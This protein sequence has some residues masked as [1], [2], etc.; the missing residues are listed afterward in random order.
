MI[1]E[2]KVT[3]Q[4]T[5]EELPRE[6]INEAMAHFNKRLTDHTVCDKNVAQ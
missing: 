5:W 6:H 1:D 2:L 3:L 4:T